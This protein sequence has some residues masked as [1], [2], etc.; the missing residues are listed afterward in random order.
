MTLSIFTLEPKEIVALWI[1]FESAC[2]DLGV[3]D[4]SFDISKRERLAC[5]ILSFINKG[6]CN[7]E[8]LRRRAVIYFTN[9]AQLGS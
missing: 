7:A 1:A 4:G 2:E 6:E 5:L 9:T 3:S 8:A